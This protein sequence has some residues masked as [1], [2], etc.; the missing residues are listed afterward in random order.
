[1]NFPK[2]VHLIYIPWDKSQKL[3][4][5]FMD[6]DLA[7]Y[8][9]FR[10]K[11]EPEWE[12]ILW[13]RD[14]IEKF[15]N[16]HY[17]TEWK[18]V[19]NKSS[20]PVM[21]IDYLRWKIVYH[22]GGVY[23]QYGSKLKRNINDF[24]PRYHQGVQLFTENYLYDLYKYCTSYY[25]IRKG[26]PEETLRIATQTFSSYPR[27]KFIQK[28]VNR[29]VFN[30]KNYKVREDYDILFISGNAMISKIYEECKETGSVKK[31]KVARHSLEVS[32]EMISFSSN[33]SWRKDDWTYY[34]PF[35]IFLHY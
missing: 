12:V 22:F 3:K 18:I 28:V 19:K 14:I 32:K 25:T 15:M 24:I 1:M 11:I 27:N 4:T 20:R 35:N 5:D 30:L 2:I 31:Y 10:K 7:F 6:F 16:S 8:N 13:T 17:R 29:I 26:E 9:K 34:I 23:W 21:W 33:G